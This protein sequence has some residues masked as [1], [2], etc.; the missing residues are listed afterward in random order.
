MRNTL[1]LRIVVQILYAA[2]LAFF[3]LGIWIVACF[4]W[5]ENP[6]PWYMILLAA[7]GSWNISAG[8]LF[9]AREIE[10]ERSVILA[11]RESVPVP[12]IARRSGR[13]YR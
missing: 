6:Y 4:G 13:S 7:C 11:R 2:C 10:S 3:F 9:S 5:P 12:K 1:F 8:C